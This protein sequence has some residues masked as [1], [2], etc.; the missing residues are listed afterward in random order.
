MGFTSLIFIAQNGAQQ[1]Y[2]LEEERHFL[3][4]KMFAIISC[5]PFNSFHIHIFNAN[6]N[7]DYMLKKILCPLKLLLE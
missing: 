7:H 4:L 6:E 2:S 1:L 3:W 5:L